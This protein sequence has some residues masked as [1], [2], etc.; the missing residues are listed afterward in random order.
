MAKIGSVKINSLNKDTVIKINVKL[1]RIFK[2]RVS[3]FVALVS[4]GVRILGASS[5]FDIT[6]KHGGTD[7]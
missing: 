1:T 5:E 2:I 6:T 7:G 4:L 3:L